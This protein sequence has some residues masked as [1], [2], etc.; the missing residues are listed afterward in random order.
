MAWWIAAAIAAQALGMAYQAYEGAQARKANKKELKRIEDL[1][2]KLESPDF[3]FE[4]IKPEEYRVVTEYNPEFHA[5]FGEM[6][7]EK[8]KVQ[9]EEAKMAQGARRK[10]LERM[11][12][13]SETG[14]DP[15][16]V[17]DRERAARR[18]AAEAASARMT[19]EREMA[20]R[21]QSLG[22]LGYASAMAGA[23]DAMNRMALADEEAIINRQR[24]RSQ[25]ASQA[26]GIGG[27]IFDDEMA[28]ERENVQAI[29]DFN[30][31]I[32]DRAQQQLRHNMMERQ[33]IA[34]A[35]VDARN[36]YK[37]DVQNLKQQ[38][39]NNELNKLG[40]KTGHS[41]MIRQE[42]IMGAQDRAGIAKG[43]SDMLSG[44]ASTM[45]A[46]RKAEQQRQWEEEQREKDRR[47]YGR[48]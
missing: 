30:R 1:I 2:D 28:I 42:N 24:E 43:V 44:A 22:G 7:P 48:V 25:A 5:K 41:N 37:M 23:S 45:H 13:L 26:A 17:I 29:N 27:Q 39:F 47:A 11:L 20:R 34:D 15:I 38:K 12:Q 8:V 35:N 18:A 10:A 40:L 19:A 32:A 4:D 21:G 14:E 9:S 6:V 46:E 16:A 31:R 3:S 36:R 33:R